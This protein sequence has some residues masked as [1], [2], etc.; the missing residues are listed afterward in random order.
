M[1]ELLEEILEDMKDE[2]EIAKDDKESLASIKAKIKKSMRDVQ[3]R[4]NYPSHFT[5]KQIAADLERHYSVI[6][7]LALY[8]YNQ[9]GAEGQTVHS[10]NGTSR[11]WKSRNDCL[12]GVVAFVAHP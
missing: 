11:T 3:E 8:D 9:K 10:E 4:R 7:D 12:Q 2:L 1:G 6:W 5:E